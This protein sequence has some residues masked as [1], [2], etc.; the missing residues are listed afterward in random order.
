MQD[1]IQVLQAATEILQFLS[2]NY[3]RESES[4][5]YPCYPDHLIKSVSSIENVALYKPASI[6]DRILRYDLYTLEVLDILKYYPKAL[7]I[8][9]QY[10][11]PNE[12]T[13]IDLLKEHESYSY[14]LHRYLEPFKAVL[15]L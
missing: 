5:D 7:V 9:C 11:E 14:I 6:L 2:I 12:T 13:T 15:Q 4:Y 3:N 10:K 1:T 8:M